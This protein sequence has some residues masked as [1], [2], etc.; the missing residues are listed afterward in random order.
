MIRRFG[1]AVAVA[2]TLSACQPGADVAISPLVSGKP[3]APDSPQP[4][5]G[6]LAFAQAACGGCHAVEAGALSPNSAAPTFP[7]I[8]NREGLSEPTLAAWLRDAH[9]Y[10]E[11]M[12][13]DLHGSQVDVLSDYILTLRSA[14][15]SAPI[16]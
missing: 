8:A 1:L 11:D 5:A 9:N 4:H 10:P 14:D 3:V 15:Y 12:E 13:F 7:D 2:L 6:T 16:S